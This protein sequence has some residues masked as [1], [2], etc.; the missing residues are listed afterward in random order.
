MNEWYVRCGGTL[1]VGP[2]SADLLRRGIAAGRVPLQAEAR[3]DDCTQW[4]PVGAVLP[5]IQALS[6]RDA[7]QPASR[8]SVPAPAQSV[9][10]LRASGLA[11]GPAATRLQVRRLSERAPAPSAWSADAADESP[12]DD[13]DTGVFVIVDYE[14][15]AQDSDRHS[16]P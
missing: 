13:E 11:P 4:Q 7:Q 5:V 6:R 16:R 14:A 15:E 12:G 10:D 8:S 3:R 9:S 1:I 2:V